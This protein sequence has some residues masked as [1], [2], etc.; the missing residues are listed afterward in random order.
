MTAETTRTSCPNCPCTV[1]DTLA[2]FNPER[3]PKCPYCEEDLS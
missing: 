3:S 1:S 2:G